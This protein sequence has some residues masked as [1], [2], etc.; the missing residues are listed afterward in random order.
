[1][2]Q[3]S[4]RT[5]STRF[6]LTPAQAWHHGTNVQMAFKHSPKEIHVALMALLKDAIDYLEMNKSF[7]H[8]GDYIEA[9]T[10]LIERFPVM[11]V[12]EWKIIT[13]RLKAG[14]YGKMYERLKLP[15]L[16]E[17]FQQHEGERAEMVE[18]HLEDVKSQKANEE[19][20]PIDDN[21][22]KM[23]KAFVKKLDLPCSDLDD[24]GRWK[25]IPYPNSDGS[26]DKKV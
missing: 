4:I 9:V 23:W 8:E 20:Q 13:T 25:Y 26:N 7:R 12:E 16:V 19:W 21:Q 1:M 3:A 14:Y 5:I 18:R 11:K 15:E 6:D 10:Y 17:I 24:R 2:I 22:K